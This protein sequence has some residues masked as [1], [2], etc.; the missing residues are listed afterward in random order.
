[1]KKGDA[2][3]VAAFNNAQVRHAYVPSVLKIVLE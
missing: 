3:G 1:L 2:F